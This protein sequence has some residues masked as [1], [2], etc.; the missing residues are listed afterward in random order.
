MGPLGR[1]LSPSLTSTT[2]AGRSRP[3]S[4]GAKIR[5]V[6]NMLRDHGKGATVTEQ[7][8]YRD[9]PGDEMARVTVAEAAKLLGIT[10]AG[11]RK[12]VQREQ[13]PHERDEDGRLW[14]WVS[15]GETRHAESRDEPDQ[16]RDELLLD[17]L[18]DR[19]RYVEDQLTAEREAHAES[20]RLLLAA[21]EKI[22]PAIEPPSQPPS[23]SPQ[24]ATP[25]P[26]RVE[27]QVPLEGAQEAPEMAMPEAGGGPLPRDQQTAASRPWWRRMFGG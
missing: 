4:A 26:G 8:Q 11:V 21:L 27:P 23:E 10:E 14:V 9:Y 25:Q 1:T 20:R 7:D 12:R 18:R 24:S 13:I 16:Y 2:E 15:P 3:R 5:T 19:L 6:P 17:E 22:P